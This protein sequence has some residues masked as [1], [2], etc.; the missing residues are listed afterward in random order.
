MAV[1]LDAAIKVHRQGGKRHYFATV[2][3]GM[4]AA[5]SSILAGILAFL[6]ADST[7]VGI[8]ALIPA[9]ATILIS[10]LKLQ[11]KANWYYK[12]KDALLG[13]YNALHFELPHPPTVEAITELSRKWTELNSTMQGDWDGKLA[14]SVEDLKKGVSKPLTELKH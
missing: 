5:G 8:F 3:L 6:K 2:A 1:D 9:M 4:A 14:L 13:L 7:L 10:S 11:E 12:K